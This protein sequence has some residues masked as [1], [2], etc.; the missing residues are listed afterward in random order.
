MLAS[1]AKLAELLPQE[2]G[3][4]LCEQLRLIQLCHIVTA[5]VDSFDFLAILIQ[6]KLRS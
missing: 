4:Y 1:A 5:C 2:C 3:L 6:F